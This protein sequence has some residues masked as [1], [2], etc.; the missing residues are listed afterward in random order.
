[1]ADYLITDLPLV[2]TPNSTDVF[3]VANS[4]VSRQLSF[5]V[6]LGSTIF[7]TAVDGRIAAATASGITPGGPAGGDL[8]GT[9]PNPVLETI[10]TIV[11]A[12][13]GGAT[14]IPVVTVD[15]KGR[16][17]GISEVP[18]ASVL[19]GAV[20]YDAPQALTVG[21][22]LVA[23][24]NIAAQESTA[25]LAAIQALA[26]SASIAVWDDTSNA[27]AVSISPLGETLVGAATGATACTTIGARRSGYSEV[28]AITDSDSP[29][30][31]GDE[32]VVLVDASLGAVTVDLP[33]I[34]A[35]LDGRTVIIKARDATNPITV[36]C[37]AADDIDGAAS[38]SL[39]VT[40][41]SYT[42][43]ASYALGNSFWSVV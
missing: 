5:Q 10:G 31:L 12:T 36:N 35:D 24:G 27:R 40:H 21:E 14:M 43:V 33:A 16:V 9:Y 34:D 19:T 11:P 37:D 30:A 15:A 4:G 26:F 18:P 6:L 17:V 39:T 22:Q 13:Y 28:E 3:E 38:L 32:E 20:R 1:M 42:L 41:E 8:D 2:S 23:R 7:N 29:Y 25:Q